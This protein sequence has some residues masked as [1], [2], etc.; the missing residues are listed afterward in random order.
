MLIYFVLGML[1]AMV[2]AVR[3]TEELGLSIFMRLCNILLIMQMLMMLILLIGLYTIEI[4]W[5]ILSV[6]W[7][8]CVHTLSTQPR[9]PLQ[10]SIVKGLHVWLI[11]ILLVLCGYVWHASPP[12]WMRDS[13]TY[14]LAL[15]K[16]YALHG[17]YVDTDFVVFS[18]FPQGWQ[19]LLTLFHQAESGTALFNPRYASVSITIATGLGIFGWL[20]QKTNSAPWAMTGALIYLLTP[21][22][23]EFGTSCYVQSWLTA[24]CLY[25]VLSIERKQSSWWIGVLVGAAISVKYSALILPFMVAPLIYTQKNSREL[26][27]FF[28]GVAAL[29][30]IF[31]VRN[32]LDTGNPVFP[33]LYEWFG[34]EGWDSWRALA[35]EKTLQNYG[36]GRDGA[37]YVLLPFRLFTTQNMHQYFQGSLGL[38]WLLL[39]MTTGFLSQNRAFASK[40][41]LSPRWMW[42][43]LFVWFIFWAVQVQQVRFFLP[44]LPLI[45]LLCIPTV[46][47]WKPNAWGL[48]I[49]LSCGWA[50][51][52]IQS[53]LYNQQGHVYWKHDSTTNAKWT[54][55]E[56]RLPENIPLYR[57]LNQLGANKVWLVWMR[58]YHYYL[59]PPVRLD[60]VFGATRFE[61]LLYE[62][63]TAQIVDSLQAD[64]ISHIAIHWRFFLTDQNADYLGEDATVQIQSRFNELI[65]NQIL[66]PQKQWGPVWLYEVV[67]S[68]LSSPDSDSSESPKLSDP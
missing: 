26:I 57:H 28:G 14:H 9:L 54:F 25:L 15:A 53:L 16:Q 50:I 3:E 34:G 27:P 47:L 58:G 63:D 12:P 23:I 49:V 38:G 61:R 18:Y 43:L 11:P 67:D 17:H 48:W 40:H 56:H 22:V 5:L 19:S 64:N 51:K 1:L 32:T 44:F 36:M 60:N 45:A 59:E 13:L 29:G 55:L 65:Q 37:D 62:K 10:K 8:F 68:E 31:L 39:L 21:S 41:S 20:K 46:S 33:L 7:A 52:P 4:Q 6:P 66:L 42:G 35:Y 2:T 30:G 24:L